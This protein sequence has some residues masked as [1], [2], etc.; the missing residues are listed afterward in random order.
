MWTAASRGALRAPLLLPA[1]GLREKA[2]KAVKPGV[3]LVLNSLP[4]KVV[5][6]KQGGRGRGASFVK[7]SLRN[8]ETAAVVEMTF[9]NDEM[10]ELAELEKEP[11]EFSWYDDSTSSLVF[12]N[13][14]SFEERR[15]SREDVESADFLREGQAVKLLRFRD[16]VIGV[17]LPDTIECTVEGIEGGAAGTVAV[18]DTGARLPVP[19][20]V[21]AGT[22]IRVNT[23]ER[24]YIERV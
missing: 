17:E 7:A 14:S 16:R 20:F 8:L 24:A 12:M 2:G 10:V 5:K 13:M 11:V 18:L 4:Y 6:M 3:A 23:A 19:E 1:R 22:K 21:K 15:V 9:T